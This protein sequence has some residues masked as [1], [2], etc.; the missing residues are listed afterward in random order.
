M[1]VRPMGIHLDY[2]WKRLQEE[3]ISEGILQTD[4]EASD[5]KY[6]RA[7]QLIEYWG[8]QISSGPPY[9]L[10]Q[11]SRNNYDGPT[12]KEEKRISMQEY[13]GNE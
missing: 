4:E 8:N 11:Q 7:R 6:I 3:L 2:D 9:L 1:H 5:L 12:L 13:E 10:G